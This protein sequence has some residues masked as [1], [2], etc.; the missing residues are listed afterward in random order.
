M[1][2]EKDS[3]SSC[4]HAK[5]L[6]SC[7]TLCNPCSPPGSSVHGL[8][9]A[10]TLE[11]VAFPFSKGSSWPRA[12]TRISYASYDMQEISH[13][14]HHQICKWH[15][16]YGRKRRGT[17]ESLDESEIGEWKSWLKTQHSK[18][19]DHGLWTPHFMANRWGNNGNSDRLFSWT[20]KSLQMVTA[21]MKLKDASY[22]LEENLWLT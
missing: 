16:P 8:L 15:H 22:S 20:P 11:W 1:F 18:N 7:P 13:Q 5:S 17:K 19:E 14:V 21:A 9:Q 10:R 3:E 12:W 4:V 2:C 6:Q